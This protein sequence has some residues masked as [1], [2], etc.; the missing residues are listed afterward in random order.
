MP[1]ISVKPT[2]I[3]R[4]AEKRNVFR[5]TTVDAAEKL[6][7]KKGWAPGRRKAVQLTE[8]AEGAL[9]FRPT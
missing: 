5:R 6:I 9:L 7:V 3:T 4:R 8:V 2:L 1:Q